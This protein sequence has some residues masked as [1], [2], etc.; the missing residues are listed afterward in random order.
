MIMILVLKKIQ[1]A[2]EDMN[3]ELRYENLSPVHRDDSGRFLFSSRS[4]RAQ[5]PAARGDKA[6]SNR[7]IL[8][9]A[10]AL[11]TSIQATHWQPQ[12]SRVADTGRVKSKSG[13]AESR[14]AET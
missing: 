9:K 4:S 1:C 12:T 3:L 11:G 5:R 13:T 14:S 7:D 8:I 6:T 10:E 2:S